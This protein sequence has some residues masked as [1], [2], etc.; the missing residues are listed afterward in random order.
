MHRLYIY[1]KLYINNNRTYCILY[2][3]FQQFFGYIKNIEHNNTVVLCRV[4]YTK[5]YICTVTFKTQGSSNCW[6]GVLV[7]QT[8]KVCIGFSYYIKNKQ[9]HYPVNDKNNNLN[10]TL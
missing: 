6:G 4:L 3:F 9:K 10:N 2:I 7:Y 5:L 1:C 8:P